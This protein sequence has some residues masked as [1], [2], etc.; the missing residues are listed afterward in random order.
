[1]ALRQKCSEQSAIKQILDCEQAK[2]LHNKNRL[3]MKG[4]RKQSL[5]SVLVPNGTEGRKTGWDTVTEG[6]AK[7][8]IL[9]QY[10]KTH[11]MLSNISLFEHGLLSEIIG[12]DGKDYCKLTE[13]LGD[14]VETEISSHYEHLAPALRE[15]LKRLHLRHNEDGSKV[16]FKWKF[17]GEDYVKAFGKGR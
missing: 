11:L 9:L 7:E 3:L 1:M 13:G 8:G 15:V 5:L 4:Q 6:V 10:N 14:E 16:E 2:E 17:D 12:P